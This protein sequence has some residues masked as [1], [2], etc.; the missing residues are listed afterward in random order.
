VKRLR[1]TGYAIAAALPLGGMMAFASAPPKPKLVTPEALI[2][3]K[4]KGTM[5]K[6]CVPCHSGKQ[7]SAGLDLTEYK[8]VAQMV[9]AR[10]TWDKVATSISTKHMPQMGMPQPTDE[11]RS[12]VAQWVQSTLT[13]AVCDVKEPGRVTLRRLNRAEYNNTVRDLLGVDIKPADDFP[14]DD[15]G[16]GFDNIGDVLSISPLLMEKYLNAARKVS[17][18]AIVAPEDQ[19]IRTAN[20]PASKLTGDGGSFDETGGVMLASNGS[21]GVD[22]F[23]A[24]PGTYIV[25]VTAFGQQAGPEPCKMA[26]LI[27][28]RQEKQ[29]D[30]R[31]TKERSGAYEA[32]ITVDKAGKQRVAA[33]FTNDYYNNTSTDPAV[34]GDRNLIVQQIDIVPF[35]VQ[36]TLVE[37]PQ[38]KRLI[39]ARPAAN[40][41]AARDAAT[42]K[43][44]ASYLPR[45]FRR[46]VTATEI[47]PIA[48]IAALTRKSGG[49]Y[50]KGLQIAVQAS[51]VSPNFLFHI[52]KDVNQGTAKRPL[53]DY[54]LATRLSYFLWSSMPD[55]R[56]RGLAAQ[57]KLKT[58]EILI[59]E[60]NRMLKDP[61]AK[62]L[63]DNF[64]GQWLQLRKINY[65]SPDPK[66]FPQFNQELRDAMR[67]ETQM[68][69]RNVVT[70]DRSILEFLDSSYSY[71]NEPLA[72]HY[73]IADVKGN[74]FRKVTLA[75][76]QRGGLLTQASILTITSNP[77][78]TSPVK[79]GKWVLDNL[80][81]TPPPPPPPGVAELPD[82]KKEPLKGTLRQR[83]E[84]HRKNAICA[85]C[86]Q[87]MDPIGFGLENFDAIGGWRVKDGSDA[88][89]ASG[90]MMDGSKFNSPDGLRKYLMSKKGQFVK[91]LTEKTMTYAL[92]RGL[93][94]ENCKVDALTPRIEKN[95][96]KY[97]ELIAAV[98]SS[99]A[100]RY[101]GA[102]PA[103]KTPVKPEAS[104]KVAAK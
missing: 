102:D 1:Q 99:E 82:D 27:G 52:E 98:V 77:T 22:Y 20:F 11:E 21:V 37:S 97:S 74:D 50:E 93:E 104:R 36:A 31:A 29:V 72:R 95:G 79:R 71:L 48:R 91:A 57:G 4:V 51:M 55:D 78:R 44:L 38:Q 16:Y 92:G 68:Y 86:H 66:E 9:K 18:A 73:G 90:E 54:E 14:S 23:F 49:S 30:V 8:T 32:Q 13:S 56:L 6:F 65:V 63:A 88:I 80:L 59:A 41:E 94:G 87:R 28:S 35:D 76:G 47:D 33:A 58:P 12:V 103:M 45:A 25:K 7:P 24:A 2:D 19:T 46:P 100:F 75:G 85:S 67:T 69:F 101:R 83:M 3:Q 5:D 17:R 15:V 42:R 61:K 81:G 43:V 89:D 60:S 84:Q 96:Y 34:K 10:A 62:A 53:N 39:S 70:E 26:F 64:A 40:T